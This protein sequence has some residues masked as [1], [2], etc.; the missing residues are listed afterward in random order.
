[1][2]KLRSQ[3][4]VKCMGHF[5][6]RAAQVGQCVKG[7]DN[8][9]KGYLY[10]IMEYCE[11]GDLEQL[12]RNHLKSKQHFE[13]KKIKEFAGQILAA[14][15]ELSQEQMIHRDIKP[16]TFS[17]LD[18]PADLIHRVIG[19]ILITGTSPELVLK[20]VN[21]LRSDDIAAAHFLHAFVCM[22]SGGLWT[23]TTARCLRR[24][25]HDSCWDLVLPSARGCA[26]KVQH[27]RGRL[28][29]RRRALAADGARLVSAQLHTRKV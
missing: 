11:G 13:E 1:M 17:F 19:N 9:E 29:H 20:L 26:R 6:G 14:L 28:V 25:R 3:N 10:I 15:C 2:L 16:G 22:F 5:V 21:I 7:G 18:V 12:F 8:C 27:D 4:V 24:V 23:C